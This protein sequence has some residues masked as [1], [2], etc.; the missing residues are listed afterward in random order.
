MRE[1]ERERQ[2]E[3]ERDSERERERPTLLLFFCSRGR[4]GSAH[5]LH[6]CQGGEPCSA[7]SVLGGARTRS[8]L[9]PQERTPRYTV[10]LHRI[11]PD[12]LVLT[13]E[14]SFVHVN[15]AH[16]QSSPQINETCKRQS[17]HDQTSNRARRGGLRAWVGVCIPFF[18]PL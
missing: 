13:S 11:A 14:P 3:R 16:V 8:D 2:R 7:D 18:F 5:N 12:T 4:Q 6:P 10:S 1:R 15:G 9:P 17:F